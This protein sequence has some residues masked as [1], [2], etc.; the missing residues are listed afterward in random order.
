M[1]TLAAVPEAYLAALPAHL[2]ASPLDFILA[3]HLRQRVL[4]SLLDRL[5]TRPRFE[6]DIAREV[7]AHIET[8]MAIHVIDEEQDLFPLLR[9]RAVPGDQLEPVLGQL[10]TEH[11]E[12]GAHAGL[13]VAGLKAALQS[14]QDA[15]DAP[16]RAGLSRFAASQRR[17]LALENAVVMPLARQ[18]LSPADLAALGGRMAARRGILL[19]PEAVSPA[20][21]FSRGGGADANGDTA[22]RE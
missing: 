10:S 2:L 6:P 5:A 22:F 3:D 20:H 16:L 14:R 12:D 21:Q 15:L 1:S 17:H 9:R 13:I 7:L 11:A 18:R 4:C 19:A 8:D